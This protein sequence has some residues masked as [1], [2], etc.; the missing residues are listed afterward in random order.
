ML[1]APF[2]KPLVQNPRRVF[3]KP[4][5]DLNLDFT[6]CID[7]HGRNTL[8]SVRNAS[9]GAR[10]LGFTEGLPTFGHQMATLV[11]RHRLDDRLAK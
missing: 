4:F 7:P 3:R 8:A 5:C 9:Y 1:P 2:R 6:L 11:H 10:D